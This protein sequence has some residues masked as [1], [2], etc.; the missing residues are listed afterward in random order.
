MKMCKKAMS[1]VL[2]LAM[3]VSLT[4]PALA[5]S[6]NGESGMITKEI[7]ADNGSR[8][9]VNVPAEYRD[10]MTD[11]R[12]QEFG[13]IPDLQEGD[14][15][16]IE[17]IGG[18]S[19]ISDAALDENITPWNKVPIYR[20]VT[21]KT[22]DKGEY[23]KKDEF[24]TSVARGQTITIGKT[25]T[26]SLSTTISGSYY[27]KAELGFKNAVSLTIQKT[28]TYTGPAADEGGNSKEYRVRFY[29]Q[30]WKWKQERYLMPQNQLE[31]TKT[32]T[33]VEATRFARYSIN[34]TIT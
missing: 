15:I 19:P 10:F 21:T 26:L 13:S 20:H 14:V 3:V 4:V 32:G 31:G 1:M 11:A 5:Q 28:E 7:V 16:N 33:A 9:V 2:A 24:I 27:D 23:I 18:V 6:A 22:K 17:N 30:N 34:R 12:I 25:F 8:V 29:A